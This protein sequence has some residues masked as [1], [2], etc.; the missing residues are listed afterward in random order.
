MQ[1]DKNISEIKIEDQRIIENVE[2]NIWEALIPVVILMC[3]LAYNIFFV[4]GQEWL[5]GY[6]S[7]LILLM[8]GGI[9]AIVGLFNKVPLRR[10]FLE[11]IENLKPELMEI[12]ESPGWYSENEDRKCVL[13]VLKGL[14]NNNSNT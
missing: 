14:A 4:E 2:L 11:I 13:F 8:G 12:M 3:L 1:D 5:G 10:M 6:T 9:A 7:Q